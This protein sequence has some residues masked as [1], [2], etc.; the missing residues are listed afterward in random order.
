VPAALINPHRGRSGKAR[1]Q[2]VAGATAFWALIQDLEASVGPS[3]AH[4]SGVLRLAD[5]ARQARNW[6]KLVGTVWLEPGEVPPEYHAPFGAMLVPGG[7]WLRSAELLTS[8]AAGVRAAGGRVLHGAELVGVEPRIGAERATGAVATAL[9]VKL[10]QAGAAG[11]GAAGLGASSVDPAATRYV[12]CRALIVATGAWQPAEL[13]LPRLE[14]VWGEA[15]TLAL[16]F[17]PSL[18]L[19][20]SVAAA[21]HDGLAFVSGGHRHV[22]WLGEQVSWQGNPAAGAGHDG[23]QGPLDAAAPAAG[24]PSRSLQNALAWQVPAAA[25]AHVVGHWEGVRAKRPSGEPVVRRVAPGVHL[26]AAFGG[27][28][29]LRAAAAATELADRLARE[30]TA[31]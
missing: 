24:E 28:G 12:T 20:G 10:R 16:G 14:L 6:Q 31:G 15:R 17:T 8:L 1:P 29:F 13:R 25:G 7:G 2:D 21:F 9:T 11:L 23:M 22:G 30:L 4:P 18:P 19:A 27:R 3:G 5:N 26:L